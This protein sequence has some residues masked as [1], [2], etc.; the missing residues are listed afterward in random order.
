VRREP[1]S[2]KLRRLK[3]VRREVLSVNLLETG[4]FLYNKHHHNR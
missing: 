3:G 2:L 1:P 4:N